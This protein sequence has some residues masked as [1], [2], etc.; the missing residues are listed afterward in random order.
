MNWSRQRK[1]ASDNGAR[2]AVI[3]GDQEHEAGV[4]TVRDMRSGEQTQVPAAQLGDFLAQAAGASAPPEGRARL[5]DPG[6]MAR[7]GMGVWS[8]PDYWAQRWPSALAR[9]LSIGRPIAPLKRG[10]MSIVAVA[11]P[12]A[13]PRATTLPSLIPTSPLKPGLPVPSTIVP[14]VIL[15]SNDMVCS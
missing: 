5:L 12:S 10:H 1:W 8:K 3:Y 6:E 4:A 9:Q 11:G 2:W 15:R 14:P 7:P 13:L